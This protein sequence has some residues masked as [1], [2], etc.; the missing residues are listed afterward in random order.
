M[1]AG[2]FIDASFDRL[3]QPKIIAMKR[4]HLLSPNCIEDPFREHNAHVENSPRLVRTSYF[5]GVNQAKTFR[6]WFLR[7]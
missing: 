5:E 1:F 2:D 4:Q 7:L 6:E 3:A